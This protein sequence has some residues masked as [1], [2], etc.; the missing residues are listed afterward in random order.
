M[1]RA[2]WESVIREG[3]ALRGLR[4]GTGG[5]YLCMW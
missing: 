3:K 4:I 2:G 1:D 5:G